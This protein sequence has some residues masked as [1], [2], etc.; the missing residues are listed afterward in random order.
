MPATGPTA[1]DAARRA[2]VLV[3]DDDPITRDVLQAV[4]EAAGLRALTA[5]DGAGMAAVLAR[6]DS[7]RVILLDIG[8][9]GKD[10]LTLTG[11]LRRQSA[12]VGLII[13]SARND[14]DD[15]LAGLELGADDYLVKPV[16]EAELVARVRGLLR[17]LEGSSPPA[18]TA[19][20][21]RFGRWV[22]HGQARRVTDDEGRDVRLT[23][24][25]FDLL[26]TF[27]DNAGAVM[28]RRQLL[29]WGR[30][31]AFEPTERTVDV[32]VRRLRRKLE[33]DP[34][35]PRLIV[36]VHRAG[37][38]FTGRVDQDSDSSGEAAALSPDC[39]GD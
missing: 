39:V 9:P 18:S 28:T 6:E 36:T 8:M 34:S 14:R 4:L 27:L 13:V 2:T 24:A 12:D 3:V 17:R 32:L 1:P 16:D 21:R 22:M 23:G 19:R 5:A 10:G 25:E 35:E 26:A 7:V 20:T 11:E 15:R 29:T 33:D 31:G 38:V 30:A 37:Y